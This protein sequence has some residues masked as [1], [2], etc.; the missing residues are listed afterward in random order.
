V[1]YILARTLQFPK[2]KKLNS[3]LSLMPIK[4]LGNKK[5][6]EEIR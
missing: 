1:D 4:V 5:K 3:I 6:E 2:A